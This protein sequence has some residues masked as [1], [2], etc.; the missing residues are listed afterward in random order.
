MEI[1]FLV[2]QHYKPYPPSASSE[3]VGESLLR[4][5]FVIVKDHARFLGIL[6]PAD[7]LRLPGTSV[8]VSLRILPP[9]RE[10]DDMMDALQ[11]MQQAGVCVLPVF[12]GDLF[13]GVVRLQKIAAYLL[14]QFGRGCDSPSRD[15]GMAGDRQAALF[16]TSRLS[17]LG[18]MVSGLAHQLNQPL[19]A[20][21]SYGD[22]SL[23]LLQAGPPDAPRIAKNLGEILRQGERAGILIRRMRALAKGRSSRFASVN[24]NETV[25]NAV[26]LTQWDLTQHGVFLN[27]ELAEPLP[28]VHADEVQIEQVLLNLMRNAID[29]MREVTGRQRLLTLRT[30]AQGSDRALVE[31]SDTGVGLPPEGIDLLFE[32]FFSTKPDGLG[33]GLSIG[34][35]IVEAHKGTLAARSNPDRGATFFFT[36]PVGQSAGS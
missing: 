2:E 3:S 12:R 13:L 30:A 32:P 31:V 9:V 6:S 19:S 35:S 23:R 28:P 29:A 18:E 4:D 22:A 5:G 24:L 25:R 21:L 36:L 34:R 26:T 8:G 15:T 14:S 1:R 33:I 7:L 17:T 10:D 16:H 27:L 20:I 11:R